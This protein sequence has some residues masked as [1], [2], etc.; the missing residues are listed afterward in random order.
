MRSS[1]E[2]FAIGTIMFFELGIVNQSRPYNE[3]NSWHVKL[4]DLKIRGISPYSQLAMIGVK[5]SNFCCK[6]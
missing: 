6:A 5:V 3:T 2:S 4:L 1:E